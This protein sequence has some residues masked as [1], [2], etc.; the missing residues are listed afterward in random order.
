MS[1][2][3]GPA[4]TESENARLREEVKLLREELRHL[5]LRV[6]RQGDQLNELSESVVG[7]SV[8]SFEVVS[9]A[10]VSAVPG[11][12]QAAGHATGCE[13]A[14]PVGPYPWPLRE[15]VAR[16]IG[17][18]L[19]RCLDGE[20]RGES[21]RDRIKGLQSRVY[22]VVRDFDR[23]V[24]NP[25]L[26]LKTFGEVKGYC[27]RDGSC[28]DSIFIGALSDRGAHS[29]SEGPEPVALGPRDFVV[30]QEDGTADFL[31]RV[32]RLPLPE[33]GLL[34]AVVAVADIDGKLLVA[35]PEGVWN[36]SVAKRLLP[37]RAISKPLLCSV[38]ACQADKREVLGFDAVDIKVWFGLLHPAM[39]GDVDYVGEDEIHYHFS[40]EG[41][42]PL[43]PYGPALVEVAQA[44]Y[45]F[46][47]ADEGI[48]K[49]VPECPPNFT[50]V[51]EERFQKLELALEGMQ[52]GLQQLLGARVGA[53]PKTLARPL[54]PPPV[55]KA[56][57]SNAVGSQEVAG[58]EPE[59]VQSALA[60]GIP[61]AHLEEM[62]SILKGKPQR[63]EELPRK[64]PVQKTK[65]GPLSESEEEEDVEA[66]EEGLPS[67]G[68]G[69]QEGA[70]PQRSMERAIVKLTAIA[71][72]LAGPKEKHKIDSL[73]DGG[74]GGV[75]GS[76]SSSIGAGRKNAAAMRAL[77]KCL[78]EDPKY[79]FQIMEANLQ[80][81]F[82]ARPIQPGEPL[83]SGTTVRGWLTARSRIQLYH[84]HVRW[85]WQVGGIWDCLIA[86]RHEEAR[87]RCALLIGAAD[88]ASID[89]GNWVVSNVALLEAP[90]PY[91]SFAT[92]QSPSPLEL[93]HSVLYDHRWAE[94]FLGHL[95]EVDSFVDAKKKL[96]SGKGAQKDQA[97][98]GTGQPKPKP[99]AK[100]REKG[101]KGRKGQESSSQEAGGS[102]HA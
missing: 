21:G 49:D 3:P 82:L 31:Y 83:A 13:A 62:G 73:L 91:Q 25:P 44:H 98:T 35:L 95:K 42:E 79:I 2:T 92:H 100:S 90:P 29:D 6:D 17:A 67:G 63:I 70:G 74:S 93:Q 15:A 38:A 30:A 14:D 7:T 45:S 78:L 24:Y 72:K 39:E 65:Q 76:E 12:S 50:G 8:Q 71:A 19:K 68:S 27:K 75:A 57:K 36:R 20:H 53:S 87:A 32:G 26:L 55:N 77:Q 86:G 34:T 41:E 47:T 43:F 66:E 52:R 64:R 46:S 56:P 16:D 99:K 22:I 5:T 1:R 18:F 40:P 69:E 10:G 28:G 101:D 59:V 81:D 9:S 88:Q 37:Q 102:N 54:P 23:K 80:S 89:G 85:A 33:L 84:N 4:G 96:G 94:T 48:P 97:E 61:L 51:S 58:L 60:A 11:G